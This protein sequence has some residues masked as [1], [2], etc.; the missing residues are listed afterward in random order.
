MALQVPAICHNEKYFGLPSFVGWNR[1]AY[2]TQ[3]KERIWARM[4]CWKEKHLSQAGKEIMI[5]SVVQSILVYSMSVFKLPVGLCKDI[6]A[7]IRKFWWGNGATKKI[8]WL[9][10]DSLCSLNQLVVW[11]LGTFKNLMVLRWPSKFGD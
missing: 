7:M 11:G 3:I 9:K 6:E 4:Q 1:T 8:H 10:W 5:K 2:F